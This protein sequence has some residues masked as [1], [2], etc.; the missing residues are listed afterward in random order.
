MN[1]IWEGEKRIIFLH[2][3]LHNCA[4]YRDNVFEINSTHFLLVEDKILQLDL[5]NPNFSLCNIY[6]SFKVFIWEKHYQ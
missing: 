5:K 4:I 3:K 6:S 1:H 2:F